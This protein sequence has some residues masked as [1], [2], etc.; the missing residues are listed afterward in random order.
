VKVKIVFYS[1]PILATQI[2]PSKDAEAK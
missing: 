1:A 2:E